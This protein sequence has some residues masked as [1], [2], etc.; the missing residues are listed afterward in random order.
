MTS[1]HMPSQQRSCFSCTSC[2]HTVTA[3]ASVVQKNRKGLF[4]QKGAL[5]AHF[6]PGGDHQWRLQAAASVSRPRSFGSCTHSV[7]PLNPQPDH[8]KT[9]IDMQRCQ[10]H[11]LLAC[12]SLPEGC[13]P[14][15]PYTPT[16]QEG[17]LLP[18]P[19]V[20]SSRRR[21]YHFMPRGLLDDTPCEKRPYRLSISSKKRSRGYRGTA[22]PGHPTVIARHIHGS[23]LNGA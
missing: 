14:G 19:A 1:K 6:I 18:S 13:A 10:R 23:P 17:M 2:A 5:G 22:Q 21:W 9:F 7:H 12:P 11:P 3:G 8:Y 4:S 20:L 15:F 16:F